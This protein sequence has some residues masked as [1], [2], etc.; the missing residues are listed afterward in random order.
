MT[1]DGVR[2]VGVSRVLCYGMFYLI[3]HQYMQHGSHTHIKQQSSLEQV[4]KILYITLF[5]YDW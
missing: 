2:N 5:V 1:G 3:L 4:Y